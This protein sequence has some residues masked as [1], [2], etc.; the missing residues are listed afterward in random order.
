MGESGRGGCRSAA[1][2]EE[3]LVASGVPSGLPSQGL[4]GAWL[5]ASLRPDEGGLAFTWLKKAIKERAKGML[6][7]WPSREEGTHTAREHLTS[8][9]VARGW[10]AEQRVVVS[11][12]V[13]DVVSRERTWFLAWH[14]DFELGTLEDM[15]V[16]CCVAPPSRGYL[17]PVKDLGDRKVEGTLRREERCLDGG[18][19]EA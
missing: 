9:A 15:G 3:L 5:V 14:G 8:I 13:G 2:G 7:D 6:L 18:P 11:T 16:S 12:A 4:E 10:S 1:E 17:D 19:A